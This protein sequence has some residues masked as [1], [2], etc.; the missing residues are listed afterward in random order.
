LICFSSPLPDAFSMFESGLLKGVMKKMGKVI[1]R[2]LTVL[3]I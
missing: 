2:K 3:N 1:S